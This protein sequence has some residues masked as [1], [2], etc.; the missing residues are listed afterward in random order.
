MLSGTFRDTLWNRT[1]PD[2]MR[3]R[4]AGVE[5]LSYGLGPT[6]GQLRAGAVAQVAG[7][8]VALWS[9]G[10]LCVLAVG[11]TCLALPGFRACDVPSPAEQAPVP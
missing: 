7:T 11:L 6:A 5:L 8:R 2:H 1:I 4:M 10:A 9:G 3:G